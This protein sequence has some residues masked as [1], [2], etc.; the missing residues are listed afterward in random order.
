[1]VMKSLRPLTEIAVPSPRPD[2]VYTT[3]AFDRDVSFHGLKRLLAAADI[4]KAG[5]RGAGLAA[6]N[7]IERE[8]A[9]AILGGLT[10]QH[11]YDHPLTDDAGQLDSVMR[12]NYDIDQATFAEIAS[13]TIGQ[14]K[15]HLLRSSGAEVQRIG[16]ALTG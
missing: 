5:D 14:L 10:L 9:R 15:D 11:L 16:P 6:R 3:R 8:A 4:S 7:E 12:V 2:E 13:L 1:M